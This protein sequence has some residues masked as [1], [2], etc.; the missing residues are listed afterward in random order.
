[1]PMPA[2]LTA[3]ASPSPAC[4]TA[5]ATSDSDVTSART[6]VCLVADRRCRSLTA[7]DIDVEAEDARTRAGELD[8]GGPSEPDPAPV[9]MNV[10][11]SMSPSVLLRLRWEA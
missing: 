4:S 3:P 5:A 11:P 7:C 8:G 2:Q 6:N 10:L 1:M 9:T